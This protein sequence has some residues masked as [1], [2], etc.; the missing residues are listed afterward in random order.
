MTLA[1]D[2]A[3]T[4]F[5]DN[6]AHAVF[7]VDKFI[8]PSASL[9]AFFARMQEIQQAVRQ[10]PGCRRDLLLQ[11]SGGAGE[12]NVVRIIEWASTEAI[13][14][15]LATMQRRFKEEGFDPTAF[16]VKQLGAKTDFGLYRV[17]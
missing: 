1:T 3:A 6:L 13:E 7:R 4:T 2:A 10:M 8:V 12:F 16:F 15:A 17:V 11:Q 14:A 5:A 9:P